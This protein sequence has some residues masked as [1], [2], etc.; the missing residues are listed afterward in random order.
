MTGKVREY[1]IRNYLTDMRNGELIVSS[2]LVVA[3][4]GY[5]ITAHKSQG[6]QWS[7]VYV[8]QNFVAPSWNGSRWY[9]TAITRAADSVEVYSSGN[10]TEISVEEINNKIDTIINET[11][12]N[13][14]T[15]TNAPEGLPGIPRTSTDCQ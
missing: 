6:S 12:T 5:A 1:L 7:K 13:R 9:Y 15:D 10:N 2:D 4:Y 11:S 14:I 3:T 8:N